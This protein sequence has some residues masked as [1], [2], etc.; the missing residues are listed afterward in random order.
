[1]S[2]AM[3]GVPAGGQIDISARLILQWLSEHLGQPFIIDKA[4]AI[5]YRAETA[6]AQILRQNMTRHD[7]A[8]SATCHLQ[9]RG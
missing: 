6:M 1:M 9:H 4:K 5:A 8:R 7:D 3:A 2:T